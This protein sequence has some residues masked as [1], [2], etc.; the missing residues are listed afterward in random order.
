MIIYSLL[1]MI[2]STIFFV[3]QNKFFQTF[4][5]RNVFKLIEI[6]ICVDF[7]CIICLKRHKCIRSIKIY[8]YYKFRCHD[9]NRY[10]AI[11]H[12]FCLFLCKRVFFERHRKI[13]EN[14]LNRFLFCFHDFSNL[15]I[16]IK[17]RFFFVLKSS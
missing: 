10:I 13:I 2:V 5:W 16:F 6:T 4:R 17:T 15:F 9:Q 7:F 11:N 1:T 14:F 3:N 12:F 8:N